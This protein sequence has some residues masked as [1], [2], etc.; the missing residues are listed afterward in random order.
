M[1]LFDSIYGQPLGRVGQE[2]LINDLNLVIG[3][4]DARQCFSHSRNG[5]ILETS[6]ATTNLAIG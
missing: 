5:I 3:E 6:R 4:L 1:S 2:E